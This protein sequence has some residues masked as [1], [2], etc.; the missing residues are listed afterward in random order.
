[1][2]FIKLLELIDRLLNHWQELLFRLFRL[3][4]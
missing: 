1:M 3:C 4:R 2:P